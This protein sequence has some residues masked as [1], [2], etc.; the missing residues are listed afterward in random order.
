MDRLEYE[1]LVTPEEEIKLAGFRGIKDIYIANEIAEAYKILGDVK[2]LTWLF[3]A[4]WNAGRMQG[5]RE[6]R[7]KNKQR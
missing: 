6:E 1:S 4:I 5:V 7:K 3:G 2:E